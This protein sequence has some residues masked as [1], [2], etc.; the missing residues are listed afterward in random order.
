MKAEEN[1]PSL[2]QIS[3]NKTRQ[4]HHYQYGSLS[5]S[6]LLLP[7]VSLQTLCLV[8]KIKQF[9][10]QLAESLLTALSLAFRNSGLSTMSFA[11]LS[12]K[13]FLPH[14]LYPSVTFALTVR[15]S[16]PQLHS[17][18]STLLS[19]WFF[20]LSDTQLSRVL[21]QSFEMGSKIMCSKPMKPNVAVYGHAEIYT[22]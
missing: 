6:P 21:C 15:W 13:I 18:S 10:Y 5:L 22:R 12:L 17:A 7:A 4:V 9:N 11:Y 3:G 16:P 14:F 19:Q 8:F 1:L 20:P 2:T